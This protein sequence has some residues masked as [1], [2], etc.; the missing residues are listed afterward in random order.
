MIEDKVL[1][2][3]RVAMLDNVEALD[4]E[5]LQK[6]L[7]KYLQEDFAETDN[8]KKFTTFLYDLIKQFKDTPAD[9]WEQEL[10]RQSCITLLTLVYDKFEEIYFK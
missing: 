1:Q 5:T 4:V 6:E 9:N 10:Q 7:K 2:M 3:A 8:H